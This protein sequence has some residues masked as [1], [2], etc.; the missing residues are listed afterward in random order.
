MTKY[1]YV[2]PATEELQGLLFASL[3]QASGD[4]GRE[5]YP[6]GGSFNW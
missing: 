6:E 4:A 2:T 5:G 1:K 3:L